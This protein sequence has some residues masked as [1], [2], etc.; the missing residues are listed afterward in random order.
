VLNVFPKSRPMGFSLVELMIGVAIIG[1]LLVLAL[2]SYKVWVQNSQI[3]NAAES[4]QNGLQKAKAEAVAR[5]SNVAFAFTNI[6]AGVVADSSWNVYEV[7]A[8]GIESRSA[9]EGSKNIRV[10][11]IPATATTVT[12]NSFGTVGIPLTVPPQN[13]DGSALFTQIKLDSAVLPAADNK[14]LLV[15]IGNVSGVGSTIRMCDCRLAPNSS[16]SACFSTC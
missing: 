16:P 1:I 3:R 9:K 10:T 6:A 11:V 8:S 4:I 2:P 5:N 15:T 7:P 14:A 13:A 12:F